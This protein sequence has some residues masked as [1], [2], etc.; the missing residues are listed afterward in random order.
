MSGGVAYVLD[1]DE[2]YCNKSMVLLEKIEWEEELNEIKAM[3]EKHVEYTASPLGKR[4]L[5]D[6]TSYSL[7]FTKVIPK[8]Y[9]NMI[10]NIDKAYKAG[11]S[12][13]E[14]LMVAFEEH[15]KN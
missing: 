7:R 2:I 3:I 11:L 5:K 14:A 15:F 10:E 9:K 8:D 6:W 13:E 1:F 12:G 4:V